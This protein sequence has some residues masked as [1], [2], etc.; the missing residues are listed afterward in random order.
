MTL[1]NTQEKGRQLTLDQIKECEEG[2]QGEKAVGVSVA[3]M[4]GEDKCVC[5][6]DSYRTVRHRR[7]N[8]SD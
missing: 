2:P 6:V 8:D 5:K 1:L 7:R 4:F 3:K